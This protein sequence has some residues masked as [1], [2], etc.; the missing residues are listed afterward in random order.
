MQAVNDGT[1]GPGELSKNGSYLILQNDRKRI[2]V[3][4]VSVPFF[5]KSV[6]PTIVFQGVSYN[7][8]DPQQFFLH[9][10]LHTAEEVMY[11]GQLPLG[12]D[13]SKVVV[14]PKT[15]RT[16]KII[17]KP[18]KFGEGKAENMRAAQDNRKD[19]D[20]DPVI[21]QA[22]VIVSLDPKSKYPYH[23][24]AVVAKDG[25]DTVTLEVIAGNQDAKQKDRSAPG[26]FY[27]YTIGDLANSFHAKW[28]GLGYFGRLKPCTI[29]IEPLNVVP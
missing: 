28:S 14:K 5:C 26:H 22:Y 6:T 7:A 17:G 16:R 13:R 20:A 18:T 29:V 4:T 19:C 24:A 3:P 27:M 1:N 11:R 2:Y 23:A 25:D 9:D 10:C 21:G 12:A 15:T 8:F